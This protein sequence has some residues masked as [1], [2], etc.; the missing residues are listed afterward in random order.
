MTIALA[1]IPLVLF[2]SFWL[3]DRHY[4]RLYACNDLTRQQRTYMM[5]AITG[6]PPALGY[7][8]MFSMVD[9]REH[10]GALVDR[11]NP[12]ELYPRDLMKR[13]AEYQIE[14]QDKVAV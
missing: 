3:T 12:F 11:R 5:N 1:L 10:Y 6:Q 13:C 9:Y 7:L 8:A 2:G 4:D 14:Q